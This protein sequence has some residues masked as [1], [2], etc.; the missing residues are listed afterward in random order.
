MQSNLAKFREEFV[1][2]IELTNP[3]EQIPALPI[4]TSYRPDAGE[5][6]QLTDSAILPSGESPLNRDHVVGGMD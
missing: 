4:R 5:P 3:D 6:S 2:Y 1:D